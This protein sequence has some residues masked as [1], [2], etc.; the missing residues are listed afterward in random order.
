MLDAIIA[1]TGSLVSF[2][3]HFSQNVYGWMVWTVRYS[4]FARTV[5]LD[6]ML[7]LVLLCKTC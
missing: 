2:V 7:N 6:G 3:R 5:K 1:K 4:H